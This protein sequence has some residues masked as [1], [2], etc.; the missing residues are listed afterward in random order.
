MP[1]GIRFPQM[2]I[3]TT[4]EVIQRPLQKDDLWVNRIPL[5]SGDKVRLVRDVKSTAGSFPIEGDF[6]SGITTVGVAMS[7]NGQHWVVKFGNE[8]RSCTLNILRQ[9]L[10]S[11][12][13][14]CEGFLPVKLVQPPP[15]PIADVPITLP[16]APTN[17][18]YSVRRASPT[19]NAIQKLDTAPGSTDTPAPPVM[20]NLPPPFGE[21]T[22]QPLILKVQGHPVTAS[23][24]AVA[25]R[26]EDCLTWTSKDVKNFFRSQ[27]GDVTNLK[28]SLAQ[29]LA[30]LDKLK[31]NG[32]NLLNL[33]KPKFDKWR[34]WLKS[35]GFKDKN[36]IANKLK[37]FRETQLRNNGS[38][39]RIFRR[40]LISSPALHRIRRQRRRLQFE[41]ENQ[42]QQ[43]VASPSFHRIRRL[44]R[45]LKFEEET[46][47]QQRVAGLHRIRQLRRRLEFE[48][49]NH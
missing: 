3:A 32:Q 22:R 10:R 23:G 49:G 19:T 25:P 4:P 39:N 35:K 42:T 38:S 47:A 7:S 16:A 17:N 33:S 27:Y 20:P 13:K 31:W 37:A 9:N 41:D 11:V 8:S 43:R 46:Q 12:A 2:W 28:Q 44:R 24:V 29:K 45:R 48:D 26:I 18:P 5:K 30:L 1:E 6:P 36:V 14:S 15:L 21:K 40:R 34:K